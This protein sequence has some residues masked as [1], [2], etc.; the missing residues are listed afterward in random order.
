MAGSASMPFEDELPDSEVKSQLKRMLASPRF[1]RATK[2]ADFLSFVVEGVLAHEKI[3]EVIIGQKLFPPFADPN[4]DSNVRF[5]ATKLRERIADYYA[6]EGMDDPVIIEI[7]TGRYIPTFRRNTFSMAGQHYQHALAIASTHFP[8]NVCEARDLLAFVA[9]S[10]PTYVARAKASLAEL[11][12]E[13]G[14]CNVKYPVLPMDLWSYVDR[15]ATEAMTDDPSLC[16]PYIVKGAIQCCNFQWDDAKD[17]FKIA[18]QRSRTETQDHWFY[19]AF[20]MAIGKKKQALKLIKARTSKR[21]DDANAYYIYSLFLYVDRQF[22]EAYAC[23]HACPEARKGSWI[24][25]VLETCIF[26]SLS[27]LHAPLNLSKIPQPG[28]PEG[29]KT[30]ESRY[31]GLEILSLAAGIPYVDDN[32]R[33]RF[34]SADFFKLLDWF[35]HHKRPLFAPNETD[36]TLDPVQLACV[37]MAKATNPITPPDADTRREYLGTA[38]HNLAHACDRH[39]P[40][41]VWL[42]LWPVFDLLREEPGFNELIRRMRLPG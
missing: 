39:H 21:A 34:Y 22:E 37:N 33:L 38:I 13:S 6:N 14:C 23:L 17:A 12:L 30:Y 10:H 26:L 4:N 11:L 8:E 32:I 15:L 41:M 5:T 1:A 24:K 29:T 19:S 7:P 18:L 36:L 40:L 9:D 35:E 27:P 20:L 25:D 16:L 2:Q 3:T 42:H 28:E 31:V